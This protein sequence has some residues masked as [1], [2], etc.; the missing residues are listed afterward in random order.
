MTPRVCILGGVAI[1]S[2]SDRLDS[3]I[4]TSVRSRRI[5]AALVDNSA[6]LSAR[7]LAERIWADPPPTWPSALRGAIASLRAALE[8]IG[9]DG[10]QLIATTA[11]GWALATAVTSDL[12]DSELAVERAEVAVAAG[13]ASAGLAVQGALQSLLR[14]EILGDDDAEWLDGLRERRRVCIE[15]CRHLIAD[16]ALA[17]GRAELALAQVDALLAISAV[18]ETAHRIRIHARHSRGDRA[19]AIEAFELCRSALAEN[20]GIDPSP[21]TVAVYLDVL[22]SGPVGSGTLPPLPTDGFFGRAAELAMALA[23]LATPG[24]VEL[25][26]RGGVGKTRL[27]LHVAHEFDAEG[28]C[29]WASLGDL[30][31]GELVPVAVAEATGVPTGGNLIGAIVEHLAPLGP[32]LLVLDGA[33]RVVDETVNLISALREAVPQLRILVTTRVPVSRVWIRVPVPALSS[34]TAERSPGVLL[35]ADRVAARGGKLATDP[36]SRAALDELCL[37]CEGIPLALELAAAQLAGMAVVD[38][39]DELP[40]VTAGADGVLGAML[41]QA[42]AA[43]DTEELAVFDRLAIVDG[44]VPLSLVRGI[45]RGVVSP[46]RVARHLTVLADSGLLTVSR[47]GARWRFGLDDELR[48]LVRE[49]AATPHDAYEGLAD[50]LDVIAPADATSPPA[51]YRDAVDDAGDGFR[52]LFQAAAD[53]KADLLRALDLGYR[54]HRY[55]TVTRMTEGR[56]WLRSLLAAAPEGPAT[57]RARFAAGYLGYWSADPE[58]LPLLRAAAS[59]LSADAPAIAARA[60]IYAAG[61]ADDLDFA[62]DARRDVLRAVELARDAGGGGLIASAT[63]GVGA[64][65]AERG[66]PAAVN[67]CTEG[68]AAMGPETPVEQRQ[69]VLANCARLAWQVGDL[70]TA[71]RWATQAAPLLMGPARIATSQLAS[72]LAALDLADGA[73]DSAQEYAEKAVSVARQLELDR[74]LPLVFAIASRVRLARGELD[75]ATESALACLDSAA[76]SGVRWALAIAL[77]TSAAVLAV[78]YP[79]EAESLVRSA[80]TLRSAGSRPAPATLRLSTPPSGDVAI[81][82]VAASRARELLARH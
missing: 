80:E 22:Q 71:R 47:G 33:E 51:A 15:R 42:R 36:R 52:T 76:A 41:D 45:V 13:T 46:G 1:E 44:S 18:D 57:A 69:A 4:V 7:R 5:L 49:R 38:L 74:E 62:D 25:T 6:G 68:I 11:N 24:V 81:P 59:E 79:D 21:E 64:I 78:D 73:L 23:G 72:T 58:A 77:E 75:E 35:I 3:G 54:L 29:Y 19:G 17:S 20:L 66:D 55:W 14:G 53:G 26:G 70:D 9:L 31:A 56:Y 48:R 34:A 61:L 28:G 12:R 39:L 8:S 40:D 16:A 63:T 37:R 82:E 60:L 30:T 65:L 2:E 50:A 43:L 32:V 27:A 67:Y 10:S